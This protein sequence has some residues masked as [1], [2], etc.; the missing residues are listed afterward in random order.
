MKLKL[1]GL[2]PVTSEST[3]CWMHSSKLLNVFVRSLLRIQVRTNIP[4]VSAS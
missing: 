3:E 1:F 4:L 2:I